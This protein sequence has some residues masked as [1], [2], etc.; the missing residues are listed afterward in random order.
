M[1]QDQA[2]QKL[3]S[4]HS[5]LR[6]TAAWNKKAAIHPEVVKAK[7]AEFRAKLSAMVEKGELTQDQAHGKLRR[8]REKMAKAGSS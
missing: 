7:L 3:K 6:K 1:T 5:K 8:I 2:H 4:L